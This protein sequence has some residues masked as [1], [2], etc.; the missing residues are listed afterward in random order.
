MLEQ[1]EPQP[2]SRVPMP[3]RDLKKRAMAGAML[4][5]VAMLI[6]LSGQQPFALLV[7]AIALLMSWEWGRLIR[8]AEIDTPF[9][10][11]AGAVVLAILLALVGLPALALAV[12]AVGSVVIVALELGR[13]STLSAHGVFY[14]GLPSLSLVWLRG[15][16]PYGFWAV[17]MLI[18]CVAAT[19][20]A[21]FFAGRHFG[22]P[23]LWPSVS[24]NK[25]WAGLLGGIA[26]SMLAAALFSA[27]VPGTSLSRFL[28]LGACC[29]LVAQAGDLGESAL[30][31]LFKVKD[32][33]SL[34]PGHGGFMDRMDGLVT[35]AAAA[36]V[37]ALMIDP[38]HPARALLL[39]T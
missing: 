25:T 27:A 24:P 5:L 14:V 20:T 28:V 39:G 8:N 33:S 30:K 7:T 22:G 6:L 12:L 21:A 4:A 23:K 16:E 1:A 19:D 36:G 34:I 9:V 3:W 15:D 37:L 32:T 26:A 2:E 29:G 17:M 11:H 38:R 13:R 35:A 31:R 18:G 10:V